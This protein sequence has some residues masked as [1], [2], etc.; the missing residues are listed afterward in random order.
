MTEIFGRIIGKTSDG[1]VPVTQTFTYNG[2]NLLET[3]TDTVGNAAAT[4]VTRLYDSFGN[5]YSES[6]TANNVTKTVSRR[7][8][9]AKTYQFTYPDGKTLRTTATGNDLDSIEYNNSEIASYSR[10]NGV[11]TAITKGQNLIET[12]SYNNWNMLNNHTVS[13]ANAD[14]YDMSYNYSRGWHLVEKADGIKN[15]SDKWL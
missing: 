11:L 7:M 8:T 12:F 3:A 2:R 9:D 14:V 6:V 4:S 10:A 5:P 15:T 1:S 13:N